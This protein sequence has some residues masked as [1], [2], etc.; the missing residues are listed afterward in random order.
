MNNKDNR[1]V[2]ILIVEDEAIIGMELQARLIRQGY[3]VP[4]V[5]D[6]GPKAI[7]RVGEIHP[8]LILM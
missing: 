2:R 3:E 5:V 8:D 7:T 1:K 6:T 4:L